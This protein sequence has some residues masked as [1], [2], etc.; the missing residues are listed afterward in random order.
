MEAYLELSLCSFLNTAEVHDETSIFS[1]EASSKISAA[2][3]VLSISVPVAL[4]LYA[5]KQAK[6]NDDEVL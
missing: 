6:T 2:I 3:I 5:C 1:V 4:F